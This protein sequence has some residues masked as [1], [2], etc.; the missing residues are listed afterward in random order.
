MGTV[1]SVWAPQPACGLGLWREGGIVVARK[2]EVELVDDTDGS[3]AHETVVFALDGVRYEIDLSDTN[4]RRLREAVADFAA[5]GRRAGRAGVAVGRR[6]GAAVP[7]A[8][9]RRQNQAI[10]EWAKGKG[11]QLADRGRIPQEIVNRFDSEISA[12]VTPAAVRPPAEAE[13]EVATPST[14][15]STRRTMRKAPTAEFR[16]ATT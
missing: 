14:A 5:H 6:G 15:K 7:R 2:V 3:A 10:R 12:A 11:L 13:A 9:S 1:G 8:N 4:A 16:A